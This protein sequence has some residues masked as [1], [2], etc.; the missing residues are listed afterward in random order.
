MSDCQTIENIF[1]FCQNQRSERDKKKKNFIKLLNKI[2]QN[3]HT[4]ARTIK[5][6]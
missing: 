3:I 4:G 1:I 6:V 2:Q 5:E